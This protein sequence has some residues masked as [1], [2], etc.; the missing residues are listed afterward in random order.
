MACREQI[1]RFG[2]FLPASLPLKIP[3]KDRGYPF[4]SIFELLSASRSNPILFQITDICPCSWTT[5]RFFNSKIISSRNSALPSALPGSAGG[6]VWAKP[7]CWMPSTTSVSPGAILQGL[8]QIV[9]NREKMVSGW[10]EISC[11]RTNLKEPYV[12]CGRQEKRNSRSTSSRMINFPSISA[13][14]RAW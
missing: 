12:S 9:R 11:Y 14:T 8:M 1:D 6:M 7:T 4:Y 13:D 5:Y 10:K 2:Y 3:G